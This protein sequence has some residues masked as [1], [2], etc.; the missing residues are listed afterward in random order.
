MKDELVSN[1]DPPVD[2]QAE[3]NEIQRMIRVKLEM[4]SQTLTPRQNKIVQRRLLRAEPESL[5]VI[6]AEE[7][8]SRERVRQIELILCGKLRKLL[9]EEAEEMGISTQI[10][11][12]KMQ[13]E[14]AA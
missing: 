3:R 10:V 14:Q 1:Y 8:I 13:V 12:E 11:F 7:G 2:S 4:F 9:R 6:A 5:E